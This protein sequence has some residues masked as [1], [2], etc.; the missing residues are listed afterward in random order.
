MYKTLAAVFALSALTVA[1]PVFADTAIVAGQWYNAA[2]GG[3]IPSEVTEGGSNGFDAPLSGIACGVGTCPG[4]SVDPGGGPVYDITMASA[5]YLVVTDVEAAGDQFAVTING[6]AATPTTNDLS[7]PGQAGL[8]NGWTSNPNPGSGDYVGEDIGAALADAN[9][10]SGT[11]ALDA[12]L[13]TIDLTYE[14][15]IGFG[16]VDFYA[17]SAAPEPG[18]ILLL[19]SALAGLGMLRRR[20]KA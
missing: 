13:N 20:K 11:F 6:V 16:T 10:S 4:V 9:F 18:T 17:S 19:G 1:T 2:F 7:L 5:G 3:T 15:V 8:A 14:G 12:G